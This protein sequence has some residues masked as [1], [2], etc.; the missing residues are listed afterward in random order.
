MQ[1][2]NRNPWVKAVLDFMYPP[3][4]LGCGEFNESVS[5]ICER[6]LD[7]V[8]RYDRPFCLNCRME[9]TSGHCC[10][11]CGEESFV[12]FAWGNYIDP[13][14]AVIHQ[15]KFKGIATPAETFAEALAG[16]FG[17]RIKAHGADRL[18]PVPLYPTREYAR[19]YNQSALLA[20]AL[21]R[22]LDVDIDSEIIVRREKRRSQSRLNEYQRRKNI[23]G[24]FSVIKDNSNNDDKPPRLI[25]VDD[26]VTSGA[27]VFEARRV[28]TEAGYRVPAVI[29]AAHGV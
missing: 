15:F 19:G 18:V 12:L 23:T 6:C 13:L 3:L 17:E 27:T 11:R 1:A 20:E 21:G 9:I 24:V 25:L 14:K 29:A 10:H 7:A 4:C 16:Q 2:L 26:V 28:L 5:D 22:R 8:E